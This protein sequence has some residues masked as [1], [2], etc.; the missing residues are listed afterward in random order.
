MNDNFTYSTDL[1]LIEYLKDEIENNER[2]QYINLMK[3]YFKKYN[4][5][6]EDMTR[7]NSHQLPRNACNYYIHN[8]TNNMYQYDMMDHEITDVTDKYYVDSSNTF[9]DFYTNLKK[10][11]N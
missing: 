10:H 9:R 4:L 2:E 3:T 1:N 5:I 11:R 6:Y 8:K 7:V